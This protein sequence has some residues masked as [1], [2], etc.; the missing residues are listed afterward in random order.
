MTGNLNMEYHNISDVD[1]IRA[2]FYGAASPILFVDENGTVVAQI[3]TTDYPDYGDDFGDLIVRT[4][5][6]D[7]LIINELLNYSLFEPPNIYNS[8]EVWIYEDNFTFYFNGSYYNNTVAE[9]FA[10][11]EE[12]ITITVSGGSGSGVTTDCCSPSGEI[13]QVAVFPTTSTNNYRFSANGTISGDAVDTDRTPHVGDWIV[14]HRGVV[15]FDENINL[16]IT[17]ANID[18]Q[19]T[20]R[21][22]W[23]P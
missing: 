12:N 6:V 7:R 14:A 1:T 3:K 19:F 13:L 17:N 9:Q 10:L 8:D 16:Y 4:L 22:R 5:T 20:V 2:R 11:R 23:R 18:E 15:L 21:I